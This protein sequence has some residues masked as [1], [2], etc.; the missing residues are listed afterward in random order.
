MKKPVVS[1]NKYLFMKQYTTINKILLKIAIYD[2]GGSVFIPKIYDC[3]KDTQ[4]S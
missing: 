4:K 2:F 1:S 3:Y